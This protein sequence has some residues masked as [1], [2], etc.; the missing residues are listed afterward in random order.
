[1]RLELDK[2]VSELQSI[3]DS[4]RSGDRREAVA[5]MAAGMTESSPTGEASRT[6]EGQLFPL[7]LDLEVLKDELGPKHPR[8][9]ELEQRLSYTRNYLSG[10]EGPATAV[11]KPFLQ[12]FLEAREE[13]TRSL[14][15]QLAQ[16]NRRYQETA[17]R[18]A[19]L[20]D[21]EIR[22]GELRGRV[23]RYKSMYKAI[24]DRVAEL[25]LLK[26]VNRVRA[27]VLIPAGPGRETP[28]NLVQ[29]LATGGLLGLAVAFAMGYL[30]EQG[31]R[32]FRS[33]GELQEEFGRP[34]LGH[35]PVIP[36]EALRAAGDS[37]YAPS[38]L[39]VHRP[40]SRLAE[41]FRSVRTGL[42]FAARSAGLKVIQVTSPDPGDGKSTLAANLAVSLGRSGKRTI[43][44]DGDLRRPRVKKLLGI[45]AEYCVTDVIDN[46]DLL[47]E[48]VV[49]T[50]L[51]DLWALPCLRKPEHPAE[52]LSSHDYEHFLE[53][54]RQKFDFVILDSPPV[55]AVSDPAAVAPFVDGVLLAIRLSKRSRGK[56]QETLGVLERAGANVLGLVVNGVDVRSEYAR[57][58]E[59]GYYGGGYGEGFGRGSSGGGYYTE[60]EPAMSPAGV[61]VAGAAGRPPAESS[62]V[63][64]HGVSV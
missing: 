21:A 7:L 33:A 12:V 54:L 18:A 61:G 29:I 45:E 31:D 36:P 2:A 24:V 30:L 14:E 5:L 64:G 34:I 26:D 15:S 25:D 11:R 57:G 20:R 6:T 32:S 17:D 8:R 59:S 60:D 28:V 62:R 38:L 58:L 4:L 56:V 37:R 53:I 55:L 48:A 9:R 52:L 23:D 42:I 1:M 41:S 10:A 13:K 22:E 43:L 49:E 44:V 3:R 40:R 50:G 46:P 39:T 47:D 35:V 27:S 16:L 63:N 51:K 19:T